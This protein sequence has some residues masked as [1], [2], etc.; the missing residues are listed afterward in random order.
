[1]SVRQLIEFH[2]VL[3]THK[4]L[5]S[6]LLRPLYASLQSDYPYRT[7]LDFAG[8]GVACRAVLCECPLRRR[9]GITYYTYYPRILGHSG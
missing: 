8:S 1:M 5:K 4:T 2:T 6:G 9:V 3:Q 7:I